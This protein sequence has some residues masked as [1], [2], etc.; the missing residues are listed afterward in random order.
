MKPI[1]LDATQ[2]ARPELVPDFGAGSIRAAR[3]PQAG[4]VGVLEP[5]AIAKP[6]AL[7]MVTEEARPVRIKAGAGLL[8]L[9]VVM[10][11]FLWVLLGSSTTGTPSRSHKAPVRLTAA[12]RRVAAAGRSRADAIAQAKRDRGTDA[13][14][15]DTIPALTPPSAPAR[16]G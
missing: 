3:R 14:L 4:T 10:V 9:I 5:T 12:E 6:P 8:L 13:E 16:G 1:D 11:A 7:V 15:Q 2:T